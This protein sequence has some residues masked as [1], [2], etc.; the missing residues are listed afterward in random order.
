MLWCA[1]E[2]VFTGGDIAKQMPVEAKK[3][4][5]I[6]KDWIKIMA[7]ALETSNVVSCCANELLKNTLPIIYGELERCQKSLEGYLE[8]KRGKFP[9]FYF[10]S[11]PVLLQILSQ[12]SDP[13]AVQKYYE[14]IF[15]AVDKVVHDKKEKKNILQLKSIVGV[16]EEIVTLAKPVYADG[17]IEDWLAVL[18]KEMQRTLKAMAGEA[19]ADCSTLELRE[20]V[21]KNCGQFALLGIQFNWTA[22]CQEALDKCRSSKGIVQV[23]T[24]PC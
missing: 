23:L 24:H 5:K 8:Q 3:F 22:E 16:D 21:D 9:R 7:K 17:N 2:S 4:A 15:D 13:Q 19:A 10:V 12:G 18:E 1:L 20:F 11:N 6:D 14:K